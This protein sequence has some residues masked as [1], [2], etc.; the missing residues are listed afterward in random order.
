MTTPD[1]FQLT[2]LL[3]HRDILQ[4]DQVARVAFL[5]FMAVGTPW[6]AR[7]KTGSGYELIKTI[8]TSGWVLD[9]HRHIVTN[10]HSTIR[11]TL[12]RS[13]DKK[14]HDKKKLIADW[15]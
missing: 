15:E 13:K 4:Y 14:K 10:L 6:D 12:D 11:N 3:G 9:L 7:Q 2:A 1:Q 5:S 8:L